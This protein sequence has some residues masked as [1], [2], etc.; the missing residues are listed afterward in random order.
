VSNG[1]GPSHGAPPTPSRC[2]GD[3]YSTC[4]ASGSRRARTR[5][6]RLRRPSRSLVLPCCATPSSGA[7]RPSTA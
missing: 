3:A 4:W 1:C 5:F 7:A 2:C 6:R